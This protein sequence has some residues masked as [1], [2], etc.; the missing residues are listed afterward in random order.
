VT[1]E[2]DFDKALFLLS[3]DES[4]RGEGLLRAV[5]SATRTSGDAVLLTRALCVL[6][7]WLIEQSHQGKA[8]T[9]LRET[10][11]TPVAD[12]DLVAYER[13][14]AKR[15]LAELQVAES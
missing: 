3:E 11:A 10:L 15:L 7:E 4:G 1:P 9:L 12:E 6:G 8:K 5:I 14:R 13:R 2:Q